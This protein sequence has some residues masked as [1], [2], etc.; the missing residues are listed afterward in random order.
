MTKLFFN[1]YEKKI[2]LKTDYV[3]IEE[4]CLVYRDERKQIKIFHL[5][6]IKYLFIDF[7]KVHDN[8]SF[9][10]KIFGIL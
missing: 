7:N 1:N 5:N 10:E 4:N 2:F 6:E 3:S 9:M 8:R